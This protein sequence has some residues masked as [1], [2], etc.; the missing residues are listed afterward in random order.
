MKG[1]LLIVTILESFNIL[2]A[3]NLF[4]NDSSSH[5]KLGENVLRE[6]YMSKNQLKERLRINYSFGH[7]NT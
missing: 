5:Y 1:V 6:N 4:I 3:N 2:N 7:T